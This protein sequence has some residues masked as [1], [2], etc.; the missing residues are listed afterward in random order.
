MLGS[1]DKLI[2]RSRGPHRI[3]FLGKLSA[4]SCDLSVNLSK[5]TST[6]VLFLEQPPRGTIVYRYLEVLAPVALS[7]GDGRTC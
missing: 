1:V 2:W 3:A 7:T 5:L 6:Q 4:S